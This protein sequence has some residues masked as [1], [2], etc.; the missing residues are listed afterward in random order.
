MTKRRPITQLPAIN[1]TATLER[2]F[3]STVDHLFQP[4]KTAA[5]SGF[6]GR[7]PPYNDPQVDFYKS[8]PTLARKKYQLEATMVSEDSTGALNDVLFYDDLLARL[9]AE[10]ALVSD[11]DRLFKSEYWSW[12]PPIDIDKVNNFQRYYWSGDDVPPVVLTLPGME[13][14]T[15]Y[16]ANGTTGT[17]ALPPEQKCWRILDEDQLPALDGDGIFPGC[18]VALVNGV[19]DTN[20]TITSNGEITFAVP[21]AKGSVIELFRYGNIGDGVRTKFAFPNILL[22]GIPH[23]DTD[24]F[25]YINGRQT[26]NFTVVGDHIVL[27]TP[28]PAN[29]LVTVTIFNSLRQ[30]ITGKR[31]FNI[32]NITH[33]PVEELINGLRI[34]LIDPYVVFF[35]FDI[36]PNATFKWDEMRSSEYFVDGVGVAI[37]LT[38]LASSMMGL[39]PQY[40]VV[41]RNDPALSHFSRINRWVQADALAWFNGDTVDRQ[42]RRPICEHLPDMAM[43]NYGRTR[44]PDADIVYGIAQEYDPTA[45]DGADDFGRIP[46]AG[47]IVLFGDVDNFALNNKFFVWPAADDFDPNPTM[48]LLAVAQPDDVFR[49]NDTKQEYRFNGLVWT[50]C[51]KPGLFPLFDLFDNNGISIGDKGEYPQSTFAGSRIFNFKVGTGLNEPLLGFPV[52]YD[53]YGAIMFENDLYTHSYSYRDGDI[54]GFYYYQTGDNRFDNQWY[55]SADYLPAVGSSPRIVVPLN[56]QANPNF[57]TPTFI[58]RNNW[59]DHFASIV[60]NQVD[61]EGKAY[62]NNNWQYT[63]RDLS[64]GTYIVQSRSPLLKL[65][66]L[67]SDNALDLKKAIKFVESEYTR[68]KLK[69]RQQIKDNLK[70][71]LY[72]DDMDEDEEIVSIF[73][74]I[75]ANKTSEFPFFNSRIGD[76]MFF[77]PATPA[78]MGIAPMVVPHFR[79]ENGVKFLV[80]HDGSKTASVDDLTDR[81]LF[82]MENRIFS[83]RKHEV[84]VPEQRPYVD[85]FDLFS[86]KFRNADYSRLEADVIQQAGFEDWA[87]ANNADYQ[88]NNGFDENNPFTWNFGSLTDRDG[89]EIPGNWRGIYR[90]YF[91]TETP[92]LTPWEMLGFVEMPLWWEDRYGYAPYRRDNVALWSDLE[93][94]IIADGPR[95]GVD[96]R[97]ARPGL[98]EVLPIDMAGN[99][100]DPVQARIIPTYPTI[101]FAKENWVFGDNSPVENLWRRSSSYSF[102][103]ALALFLMRPA[104]FVEDYWDRDNRALVHETQWI[105]LH[106]NDRAASRELYVHGE[107]IEEGIQKISF[108]IQNWLVEYMIHHGQAPESLGLILRGLDVHLAHKMAGFTTRDRLHV[109]AESFGRIPDEDI[110]IALYQTPSIAADF[111]SGVIVEH[112]GPSRWR[113][114]GYNPIDPYFDIIPSD[115]N[116]KKIALSGEDERV[117]NPWL[118]NVYYKVGMFIL[119]QGIV[120]EAIKNHQSSSF[121]E[122]V[123]WRQDDTGMYADE[124]LFKYKDSSE[125]SGRIPYTTVMHTRQDVVDFIY[126]YQR[127]LESR[128]FGFEDGSWDEAVQKFINWSKV[129]WAGGSFLT[130]SPGAR[131]LT[132]KAPQGFV[133]NLEG[134]TATGSIV[135]RTGHIID[136]RK[137]KVDRLEDTITLT[138]SGDDIYGV[139]LRKGEIEHILVFSNRTIFGDIIYDTTLNVRQERLKIHARRTED[140]TGRYDAP[141]FIIAEGQIV[142]NFDKSAED[143]R[144]MFDIEL[145]DNTVLRDHARHVIGFENRAY[146]SNLLLNETQQFELYQGM[147]QEKG[148]KGSLGKIMRSRAV[149]GNRDLLFMEEWAFRLSDFGAYNPRGYLEV[150]LGQGDLYRQKQIVRFGDKITDEVGYLCVPADDPRWIA[151]PID[152]SQLLIKDTTKFYGLPNA[153]Y[154]RTNEVTFMSPT[155]ED[156]S[157]LVKEQLTNRGVFTAGESI[158]LYSEGVEARWMVK[159]LTN[160][161]VT[162]TEG[163]HVLFVDNNQSNGEVT[164]TRM[165]LE[166]NHG[167]VIGDTVMIA[168]PI[169]TNYD[170]AGIFTVVECDDDWFEIDTDETNEGPAYDF[171][172]MGETGP[173]IFKLIDGRFATKAAVSGFPLPHALVYI[174]DKGDGEWGVYRAD[175]LATPLRIQPAQIDATKIASSLIYDQNTEITE[176]AIKPQPITLARITP[177][178]PMI[179]VIVGAADKEIDYKLEYDPAG[180]DE[181]LWTD[182]YVGRL[183]W[184]MSTVWFLN[185]YTNVLDESNTASYLEEIRYRAANWSTLAPGSKVDIYE[186]TKS[187]SPPE[188]SGL[189]FRTLDFVQAVEYSGPLNKEVSV[190]YFW[191]RNPTSIPYNEIGRTLDAASCARMI[192]DPN[193]AG[194]AWLAAISPKEMVIAGVRDYLNDDTT[195][196]QLQLQ[197]TDDDEAVP[198]Q[199]WLMLRPEDSKSQPPITMLRKLRDS[200]VGF[201]DNLAAI[202]SISAHASTRT[203]IGAKQSMFDADKKKLARESFVTMLNYQFARRNLGATKSF[204]DETLNYATP[205]Q[206]YLIWSR[207]DGSRTMAHLPPESLY[208]KDANGHPLRTTDPAE[209]D[210]WF[211]TYPNGTRILLDNRFSDNPSWSVWEKS[212]LSSEGGSNDDNYQVTLA[213]H[214]DHA[215]EDLDELN[216]L[217]ADGEILNG[218]YVLVRNN[219]N[220]DGLWTVLKYTGPDPINNGGMALMALLGEDDLIGFIRKQIKIKPALFATSEEPKAV[221]EPDISPLF[222]VVNAQTY[223]T[224]DFWEYVDWYAEGFDPTNPPV[225]TY[226]NSA[227]RNKYENPS[228]TNLFVKL[229]DNGAGY[230]TWTALIDGQWTVVAQQL[231]TIQLSDKFIK[232]SEVYGWDDVHQNYAFDGKK[233]RNRDGSHELRVIADAVLDKGIITPMEQNELWFS[234]VNFVHAHH[235]RVDWA[236]KTSFLT[237]VGFNEALYDSPVA[238]PDNTKFILSYVDEVKPYHVT[239]RDFAR[240]YAPKTEI[241]NVTVTDFDKPGYYDAVE[242]RYRTL[243]IN[244]PDD[245]AIMQAGAWQYWL[246][247]MDLARNFKVQM[248]FDRIWFEEGAARPGAAERIMSYYQPD[249]GMTPKNLSALLK[250]D[251]KGTVLDGGVLQEPTYPEPYYKLATQADRTGTE[252][253]PRFDAKFWTTNFPST[254]IASLVTVGQNSL[255]SDAIFYR[256]NDLAGFI[257]ESED[258]WDHPMT[259]YDTNRDYRG[260]KLSFDLEGTN[261]PGIDDVNGPTLTLEGRD[262]TGAAVTYYVRLANY[263]TAT[264]NGVSHV[265]I[266]FDTVMAGFSPTIPVYAGDLDRIFLA[267]IPIDYDINSSD[268]FDAPRTASMTMSNITVEGSNLANTT[269]VVGTGVSEDHDLRMTNGYDDTYNLTPERLIRNVELMGYKKWFN[270]Y[271]GMSHYFYWEW[272]ATEQR[273]ISQDLENPLNKPCQIWHEELFSRLHHKGYTVIASISYEMLNSFMP[274]EWRQL[275]HAGQPALSGWVPPSTLFSPCNDTGMAYLDRVFVA[276]ADLLRIGGESTLH[277]QVGEPWWWV[278]FRTQIPCFYDEQTTAKWLAEKGTTAPIITDMK[279]SLNASQIE[280]LDWLGERLAESTANKIQAVKNKYGSAVKSYVLCYLPQILNGHTET[281]TP[282]VARVNMPLGWAFPAFDILQLEDYDFVIENRPDLSEEG[283]ILAEQRLGYSRANQQYFSGFVLYREQ[284]QVWEYTANA[285]RQAIG[286]KVPEIFIWAY[287]QVMRDGYLNLLKAQQATVPYDHIVFGGQYSATEQYN[288]EDG[289][290]TGFALR[291]PRVAENTPEELVRLG[292]HDVFLLKAHDKWGAGAPRSVVKTYDVSRETDAYIDLPIG[293]LAR[294]VLVFFDGV[295]GVENYAYTVDYLT[296]NVNVSLVRE[297]GTRVE[298]ITIHA[299]GYGAHT[300]IIDQ[301]YHIAHVSSA[302][303]EI[304]LPQSILDYTEDYYYEVTNNG[305][306]I[307][308][309]DFTTTAGVH[310]ISFKADAGDHFVITFYKGTEQATTSLKEAIMPTRTNPNGENL[311]ITDN[312]LVAS[313]SYQKANFSV[314]FDNRLVYAPAAISNGASNLKIKNFDT[315]NLLYDYADHLL[316]MA[317]VQGTS[318]GI[319]M[320][321]SLIGDPTDLR[322]RYRALQIRDLNSFDIT[323]TVGQNGIYTGAASMTGTTLADTRIPETAKIMTLRNNLANNQI[324]LVFVD[325]QMRAYDLSGNMV[326]EV[327]A[328]IGWSANSFLVK[329]IQNLDEV[330]ALLINPDSPTQRVKKITLTAGYEVRV[331]DF[332]LNGLSPILGNGGG[333]IT[334]ASYNLASNSLILWFYRT[335]GG[336]AVASYSLTSD[337]FRW[338]TWSNRADLSI[339]D[340]FHNPRGMH[341]SRINSGFHV[342]WVSDKGLHGID[343][344]TGNY[345]SLS[346]TTRGRVGEYQFWDEK[347][348][349]LVTSAR[350]DNNSEAIWRFVAN[351]PDSTFAATFDLND[352]LLGDLPHVKPYSSSMIVEVNGSRLA[353][354]RTYFATYV[355]EKYM[356]EDK[357]DV[358]TILIIDDEGVESGVTLAPDGDYTSVDEILDDD[359][360]E[361]FIFWKDFVVFRDVDAALRKYAIVIKDSGEFSIDQN[362]IMTVNSMRTGDTIRTLHWRNDAIM[363]P[364]TWSFKARPSGTYRILTH[365]RKGS[366]WLT[367]NGRR[368]VEDVDYYIQPTVEGAWDTESYEAFRWDDL[369]E[370]EITIKNMLKGHDNDLVVITTFE[371]PQNTPALDWQHATL[372]PDIVRFKHNSNP[373]DGERPYIREPGAW[374]TET[375]D[376]KREGGALTEELTYGDNTFS[377]EVNPLDVPSEMLASDAVPVPDA[378]ANEPGVVWLNA[379]R[380]E[381]FKRRRVGDRIILD[382]VR[383]GTKGTPKMDHAVG[384]HVRVEHPLRRVPAAPRGDILPVPSASVADT[385][386]VPY[387]PPQFEGWYLKVRFLMPIAGGNPNFYAYNYFFNAYQPNP[388]SGIWVGG[389]SAP[390]PHVYEA[391][392]PNHPMCATDNLCGQPLVTREGNPYDFTY[393]WWYN[394]PPGRHGI[395]LQYAFGTWAGGGSPLYIDYQWWDQTEGPVRAVSSNIGN[396]W[397]Y[398]YAWDVQAKNDTG[399]PTGPSGP[400]KAPM[401][402]FFDRF[403]GRG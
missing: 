173:L 164:G 352:I 4:G 41:A 318:F 216:E 381:Y 348:G 91:D 307:A 95:M 27:S 362:G 37:H 287:T 57:D 53:T 107:E 233:V 16:K 3:G 303:T 368:L 379:E 157:A 204:G 277:I 311:T 312:S 158:W 47:D 227:E 151:D 19:K 140:W 345:T 246:D 256:K 106:T 234:M 320:D 385:P 275:D 58:S 180:Y 386:F 240:S 186:W 76:G 148:A 297:S 184:D 295:R 195:V 67:M 262:A 365:A 43:W 375:H 214:Y 300:T 244:N 199:E 32:E 124:R 286:F 224:S 399:A 143:L 86:G 13:I 330:E 357:A 304:P 18:P 355:T 60:T 134:P 325:G 69:V 139:S 166:Y 402:E 351:F 26:A 205:C 73:K 353:P 401:D 130:L 145:A 400:P 210:D 170:L 108:G 109:D 321:A 72:T 202:P 338:T 313:G 327:V 289:T 179:G 50:E 185:P 337:S 331:E 251:F 299:F 341:L 201:D 172:A 163:N 333:G 340:R 28:A 388:P 403:Y 74:S 296:N 232:N 221:P 356:G 125:T 273:F 347:T 78:S 23:D 223:R 63:Q 80:G 2:F 274:T 38:D 316:F 159:Y 20:F 397:P 377:F 45:L 120:Y 226:A 9:S 249:A 75:A 332:T 268:V 68:Y 48:T 133:L 396:L 56:L 200:L 193:A 190:Y 370:V 276:F 66:M 212:A 235:D 219:S 264:V 366:S 101:Q 324:F 54:I 253:L 383:R 336:E 339:T 189:D 243:D 344:R 8:E 17:F 136:E 131:T 154:V 162:G 236:F 254:M 5:I 213:K 281:A 259:S 122:A 248:K 55:K 215:V 389:T 178:D 269:M 24:V 96:E 374:A 263:T 81:I 167:L 302:T 261:T 29:A 285:I 384:T 394:I 123:F 127:S 137:T 112:M 197:L 217:L 372:T 103:K 310:V 288:G 361:R 323:V 116:G 34:K 319:T 373:L 315:N 349:A 229:L 196:L 335:L 92:H 94:G 359:R 15:I 282:E 371:G 144:Y 267:F 6:I 247:N 398:Y 176:E 31:Y 64:R 147:I 30:V 174:D 230:W 237:V 119:Y 183:W 182:D 177:I 135:N 46:A 141:G 7:V 52:E 194:V 1:R 364:Q 168:G 98:L 84:Y 100:L 83:S 306:Y 387:S 61:I 36:K 239:V 291:D 363:L 255:R 181:T 149:E 222:E 354:P 156:F 260:V 169:G 272:D 238:K 59:F 231:G 62:S 89:E 305:R 342:V 39:D 376:M 44:A 270:H 314:D 298:T 391:G 206:E 209:M 334:A 150:L 293:M 191:V 129:R 42:A 283:R 326:K 51:D 10:G 110:Q 171:E 25:V 380:I 165:T 105:D 22:D 395:Q 208:S 367:I 90:W 390:T 258:T 188:E 245:L 220:F 329:T 279:H 155:V 160:A 369:T 393:T 102:A 198:H 241:A 284:S 280:Y 11:P 77:I 382:Q 203:G 301:I 97:F 93:E 21:P 322:T 113:V 317:P 104:Q 308:A 207:L 88:T 211:T 309:N 290:Q 153:G 14:P 350:Y 343:P 132:Y 117:V 115:R 152:F 126:S 392:S 265:E 161:V 87:R 79:L 250:L 346:S 242:Q 128:G 360:Q 35:G 271:V 192:S 142:T 294:N 40:V 99:L 146:L 378:T 82:A 121:F 111:Y 49:H 12:A 71:G 85:E 70:L 358:S 278:D 138:A 292:A 33:Q 328:N 218:E 187:Y 65:M 114:I 252:T 228:P 175:D 118:P 225:V 257:W 266:D